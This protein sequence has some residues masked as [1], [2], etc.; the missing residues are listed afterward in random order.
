VRPHHQ[1]RTPQTKADIQSRPMC[2][3]HPAPRYHQMG[4]SYPKTSQ[5]GHGSERELNYSQ[6]AQA[7]RRRGGMRGGPR[8]SPQGGSRGK[9]R[10][11]SSPGGEGRQM[12][13]SYVSEDSSNHTTPPERGG[14][15]RGRGN[16][17]IEHKRPT[18][19]HTA[20]QG[21]MDDNGFCA[22]LKATQE[23]HRNMMIIHCRQC[24]E[25]SEMI[26]YAPPPTQAALTMQHATKDLQQNPEQSQH[27]EKS[28]EP[29]HDA[30]MHQTNRADSDTHSMHTAPPAPRHP[31]HDSDTMRNSF[32]EKYRHT[33]PAPWS[34]RHHPFGEGHGHPST[35]LTPVQGSQH[36][37]QFLANKE[38]QMQILHS[39]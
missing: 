25:E 17:L 1:A 10:E 5:K 16:R 6:D 39:I 4:G 27:K 31:H 34:A 13:G 24:W 2:T 36:G 20:V 35:V 3:T 8:G 29:W 23:T 14:Q 18:V 38:L 21:P 37:L 22:C 15:G 26:G 9:G 7:V 33:E 28:A 12:G 30:W 11:L 19:V 32:N